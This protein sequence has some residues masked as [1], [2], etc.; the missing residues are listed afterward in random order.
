MN[1]RGGAGGMQI[2]HRRGYT[3]APNRAGSVLHDVPGGEVQE[4]ADASVDGAKGSCNEALRV[5]RIDVANVHI[6]EAFGSTFIATL[7][8]T[9]GGELDGDCQFV[10]QLGA[11]G[12]ADAV[13]TL[14][15]IGAG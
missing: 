1:A 7:R 8:R 12:G 6:F 9:P 10:E 5:A 4:L 13:S 2:A 3:V 14:H 15:G 11:G